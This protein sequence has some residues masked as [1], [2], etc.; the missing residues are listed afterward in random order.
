MT[1]DIV[2]SADCSYPENL[3]LI[4]LQFGAVHCRSVDSWTASAA[5]NLRGVSAPATFGSQLED[6]ATIGFDSKR[7][8]SRPRDG[9]Q[10][11]HISQALVKLPLSV[12]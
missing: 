1:R 3:E 6:C 8:M 9:P 10:Q 12:P 7:A 2:P 11:S 4:R 5:F